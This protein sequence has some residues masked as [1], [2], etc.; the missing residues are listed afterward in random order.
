[1]NADEV[2]ELGGPITALEDVVRELR[3]LRD[4][5]TQP[6][7]PPQPPT[8]PEPPTPAPAARPRD[9]RYE[10][11]NS[12]LYVEFRVDVSAGVL[13]ADVYR[14]GT[15]GRHYVASVRSAPGTRVDGGDRLWPAAWQDSLGAISTGAIG[16]RGVPGDPQALTATLRLD[17]RLNGL[18]PRVDL[19]VI[20]RRAGDQLR[21][22][23]LEVETEQGV[24]LPGEV[25]LH[26][27]R[28]TFRECLQHAG[29]AVHDTGVATVIPAMPNGWN[30]SNTYTVLHDL[31]TRTAQSPLTAPI[32]ELHALMLGKSTRAG[33]L[34]VMFDSGDA[35]PRQ[36]AAVFVSEI[37]ARVAAPEQD[38]KILQTTV[39]ELGHALNLAHRFERVVGRADSTSFMNYDW[40]FLGGNQREEY[41]RRF[42]FT[43]DPDELEFLHHAPRAALIPGGADFHSI[44]YWAGGTGGYSPYAPEVPLPGFELTLT[45]PGTGS[46]FAFG[47]PVFLEVALANRG[48][49]PIALPP[50]VLDPKAGFLELL[51]RRR[52][53]GPAPGDL[54]SATPFIPIMQRCYDLDL[55]TADTLA[56]GAT[57]RNNLNLTFGSSGFAFAEP[58]EYEVTA[59]L[60]FIVGPQGEEQNLVI[61]GQALRIRIAYPHDLGDEHDAQTL[62]H[63]DV[64]AWFALGGSDCLLSAGQELEEVRQRRISA[65]G[66][67]DPIVA[68]ITRAAGI[69]VGR[70]SVRFADGQFTQTDG[71]PERAAALLNSLDGDALSTFDPH[72]AEHTKLLASSYTHQYQS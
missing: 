41:W 26:G 29:F 11:G 2:D 56:P 43:F 44:S 6:P 65:H 27:A 58:G 52:S 64:G 71:D 24:R 21:R 59:L 49:R 1:M 31:M 61:R 14:T 16:M 25:E 40:R 55:A 42:A 67:G 53:G 45:P 63:A 32:W 38:R 62:L 19:L 30:L 48:Q 10:G 35:L 5:R 8:P 69:Y 37:R 17:S 66:E 7:A 70:P 28:H 46:V 36:G 12:D 15:A 39:H 33:L 54:A 51:V 4:R 18:Q 47:Q 68:A 57:M 13:S 72:T 60:S 3:S 23:G 34:G 9:G 50:E 20:A 22:L